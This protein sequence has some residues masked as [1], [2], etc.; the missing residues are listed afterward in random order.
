[1][2]VG[3]PISKLNQRGDA[4]VIDKYI[5]WLAGEGILDQAFC[6]T[7][8]LLMAWVAPSSRAKASGCD[9]DLP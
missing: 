7:L 6:I 4:S 3:D 5:K 9:E 1:M 2:P 8:V